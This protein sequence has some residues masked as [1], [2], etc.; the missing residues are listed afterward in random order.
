MG[1]RRV[2]LLAVIGVSH[3]AV[4]QSPKVE[5]TPVPIPRSIDELRAE[6]QKVVDS[7]KVPGVGFA[8][9]T[10]D[11][12]LYAGG[13]GWAD[14]SAQKAIHADTHFRTGSISKS[15]VA[16]ALLMLQRSGRVDLNAPLKQVAPEI[17]FENR[18]EATDPV[19]V[20]HLLEH[21]TGF[22]DMH[23]RAIYNTREAPDLPLRDVLA[24]TRNSLTTRW[25]P[26]ERFSYSNPGYGI[27]GYVIEKASGIPY[28][29]FIRDSILAPLGMVTSAFTLSDSTRQLMAQGYHAMTDPPVGFPGIYLRPAGDLHASPR[30]LA[31]FVQMLL[32]RGD[33]GNGRRLLDSATIERM[34]RVGSTLAAERGLHVGYGLGNYATLDLPVLMHGHDGGIDGFASSYKYSAE[35]G[36]G[37]IA[38]V[39]ADVSGA[40]VEDVQRLL[41]LYALGDSTR[42]APAT[43]RVPAA[44]LARYAGYYAD[45]APRNQLFA[46]INTLFGGAYVIARSDSLFARALG[47]TLIRLV[48]LDDSTFRRPNEVGPSAGFF[49]D[50]DGRMV[51]TGTLYMQ[52][53]SPWERR[54]TL[55]GLIIALGLIASAG[56]AALVWV[57]RAVFGKARNVAANRLRTTTLFAALAFPILAVLTATADWQT[58]GDVTGL[59]LAIFVFSVLVPVLAAISLRAALR[60]EQGVVGKVVK[61][62]SVLVALALCGVALWLIMNGFAGLRTWAY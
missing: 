17:A 23:F 38:L 40:A 20:V 31:R 34:E 54:L 10:K 16:A 3:A 35:A 42:R 8:V 58:L 28:D 36:V 27:A 6:I 50:R 33:A 53:T 21:T 51:L 5:A 9:F 48:P 41:V 60:A 24:H 11:S 22:D 30:E 46:P 43:A 44:T 59:T 45:V 29:R 62:H 12:L 7:T 4:A 13:V 26:G 19:R 61:V 1:P 56:L 57:P 39:N 2:L 47:D 14:V 55:A 18:W 52:R 37:V 25:R 15:F 32:R 49:H